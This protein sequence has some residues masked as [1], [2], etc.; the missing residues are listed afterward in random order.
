MTQKID[1][2]IDRAKWRTGDKGENR[3]GEGT[4]ALLNPEGYLCCLGFICKAYGCDDKEILRS[5]EPCEVGQHIIDL[6]D[7]FNE[8]DEK[9]FYNS[10]LTDAAININ[11]NDETTPE[12]KELALLELFKDSSY[13]LSFVGDFSRNGPN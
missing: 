11:D 6:V 8:D 13:N 3:T 1:V 5:G 2:I 4:T 12:E 7:L 10:D 9:Y